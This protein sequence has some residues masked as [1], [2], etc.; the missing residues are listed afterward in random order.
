MQNDM[1]TK[2]K[3][4]GLAFKF[5]LVRSCRQRGPMV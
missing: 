2:Y 1:Q 3:N 4:K 5:A